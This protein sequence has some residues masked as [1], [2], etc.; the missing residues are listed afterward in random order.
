[1]SEVEN[2]ENKISSQITLASSPLRE[3]RVAPTFHHFQSQPL[4]E[5]LY[6]AP[7]TPEDEGA[8][9]NEERDVDE[10]AMLVLDLASS[11]ASSSTAARTLI[12]M[13][14]TPMI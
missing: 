11:K 8:V 6:T 5:F 7:Q 4:P 3:V 13:L 10:N 1:M 9:R 14:K 12:G 2:V